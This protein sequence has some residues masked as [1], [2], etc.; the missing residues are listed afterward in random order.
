[1]RGAIRR[2]RGVL[3]GQ[4][5]SITH[6]HLLKAL[7]RIAAVGRGTESTRSARPAVDPAKRSYITQ[8]DDGG[9]HE[10]EN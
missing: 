9:K 6:L 2:T 8:K 4:S 7:R 5:D 1:M 10:K 3:H